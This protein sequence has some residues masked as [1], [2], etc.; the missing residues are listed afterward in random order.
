MATQPENTLITRIRSKIGKQLLGE[1]RWVAR[2]GDLR[3]RERYGLMD[4]PNY[5]YG[6]LRAADVASS[7]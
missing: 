1:E 4:R 3:M 2:S 5:A 6:M 7:P